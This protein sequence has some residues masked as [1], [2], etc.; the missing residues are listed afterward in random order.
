MIGKFWKGLASRAIHWYAWKALWSSHSLSADPIVVFIWLIKSPHVANLANHQETCLTA[1]ILFCGR[2][3]ER[4]E[5]TGE[6]I[7]VSMTELWGHRGEGGLNISRSRRAPAPQLHCI[8][9]QRFSAKDTSQTLNRRWLN[10]HIRHHS[11]Q[12]FLSR[13]LKG[14]RLFFFFSPPFLHDLG[15]SNSF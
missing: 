7:R 9:G 13:C 4:E 6:I 8:T 11:F 12:I 2:R 3:K 1:L 14:G 15:F 5:C 10:A